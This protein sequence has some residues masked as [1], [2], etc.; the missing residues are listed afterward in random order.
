[1]RKKFTKMI[2]LAIMDVGI[3]YSNPKEKMIKVVLDE[4]LFIILKQ[5][6]IPTLVSCVH[7]QVYTWNVLHRLN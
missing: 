4:S 2:R 3:T 5:N 1:M 7:V 6:Y